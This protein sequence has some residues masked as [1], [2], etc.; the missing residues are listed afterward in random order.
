M[1]CIH[2]NHENKCCYWLWEPEGG[3]AYICP[4]NGSSNEEDCN[5]YY[6]LPEVAE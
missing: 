1:M 5:G 4:Y 3:E 6:L 2:Y